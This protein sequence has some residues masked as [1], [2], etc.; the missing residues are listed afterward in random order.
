MQ[1][2]QRFDQ[3]QGSSRTT[4]TRIASEAAPLA[5]LALVPYRSA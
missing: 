3:K 4:S 5:A 2:F 1:H